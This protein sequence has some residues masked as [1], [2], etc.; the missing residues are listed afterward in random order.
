MEER[1][2]HMQ[3][4]SPDGK[5]QQVV[6]DVKLETKFDRF[7]E[8]KLFIEDTARLSERRQTVTTA[9]IT[10]NGAIVAL[11]TFV[12]KDAAIKDWHAVVALLP[13]ILAGL[14]VCYFWHALL[15][16][17]KEL[18]GFRFKQLEEMENELPHLYGMYRREA[19]TLYNR[20]KEAQEPGGII[21]QMLKKL[22]WLPTSISKTREKLFGKRRV[23]QG[24]VERML[25]VLFGALYVIIF[26]AV[27]IFL[28]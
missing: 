17:Y 27:A 11:I 22:S 13:L 4:E 25:P 12:F 9:Y 18:L 20:K 6:A 21:P 5:P 28:H 26:L 8:Y 16:S 19:E 2:V 1:T 7:E 14:I 15:L 23:G 3:P 10:V 24:R